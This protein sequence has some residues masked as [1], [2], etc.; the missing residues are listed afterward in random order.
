MELP[1]SERKRLIRLIHVAKTQLRLDEDNY[2]AVLVGATGKSSC[3]DMSGLEIKRAYDA[4]V[5]LGFKPG[6]AK[7]AAKTNSKQ[8]S[9]LRAQWIELHGLGLVKDRSDAGLL[10]F[11]KRLTGVDRLEWLTSAQASKA[12]EGLKAM[13]Q[14]AGGGQ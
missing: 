8:V 1:E 13:R 6:P 14:R 10:K 11:C 5:R 4:M 7:N 12:I 9:K 3:S 2:R